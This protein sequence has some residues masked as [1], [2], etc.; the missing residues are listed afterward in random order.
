MKHAAALRAA[1]AEPVLVPT[2]RSRVAELRAQGWLAEASLAE[3]RAAGAE[4][5]IVATDTGRHAADARA[6]LRLGFAVLAEKPL[7]RDAA[8]ALAVVRDARRLRRPLFVGCI[9][10]FSKSLAVFRRKL[11]GIGRVHAVAIE[12]RSYMPDWRPGREHRAGYGARAGEGGVLRDLIHEVDYAGWLFG[13]PKSASGWLVNHGRLGI[14][15]EEAAD[16]RWTAPGGAEVSVG[17]D[18]LTRVPKR[19]MTAYGER[20]TLEWDGVGQTVRLWRPGRPAAI[21]QASQAPAERLLAQDRAF[22]RGGKGVAPAA[23][24]VK[25]LAVCDAARRSSKTG[26]AERVRA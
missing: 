20:G 9:L 25:A 10:R 3:A 26:R 13:W 12:C 6:A 16:L 21:F 14:Q 4:L 7:A 1:K 11:P 2:R 18:L 8:E 24:G 15:A 19:R 22:L 5:C 23:D 17:L